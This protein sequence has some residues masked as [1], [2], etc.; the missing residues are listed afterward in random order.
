[1]TIITPR[2][3]SFRSKPVPR[4]G[5]NKIYTPETLDHYGKLGLVSPNHL[6]TCQEP[7]GN[8]ADSIGS[9]TLTANATPLYNQIVPA[10]T[11]F[12][13]SFTGITNQSFRHLTF[14][15]SATTSLLSIAYLVINSVNGVTGIQTYGT[16]FNAAGISAPAAQKFRYRNG[17]TIVDTTNTYTGVIPLIFKHDVT[18][19]VARLYT[20]SEKL[21]PAFGAATGTIFGYGATSGA[22]AFTSLLWAEVHTG[23]AAEMSDAQIKSRLQTLGWTIAWI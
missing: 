5:P 3:G 7:S 15:N 23:T 19:S 10:W 13:V 17:G 9:L 12:G 22:S 18:N 2:M 4:D 11:R 20:D 16:S 14:A 1:M 6:Y 8:L 21:S